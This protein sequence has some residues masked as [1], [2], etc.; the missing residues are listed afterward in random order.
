M[1]QTFRN[2]WKIFLK[3][4]M[5][6]SDSSRKE[7]KTYI[8]G[9]AGRKGRDWCI[10][11]KKQCLAAFPRF[12]IHSFPLMSETEHPFLLWQ[13]GYGT[14]KLKINGTFC[15]QTLEQLGIAGHNCSGW[16]NGD[17]WLLPQRFSNGRKA[18]KDNPI[19]HCQAELPGVQTLGWGGWVSSMGAEEGEWQ[20]SQLCILAFLAYNPG[21][22]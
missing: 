14:K 4:E 1:Q 12:L 19:G 10:I 20:N 6:G 13:L 15:E 7:S 9:S 11:G 21:S 2:D 18:S 17:I 22:M 8:P 5:P 16:S 3:G